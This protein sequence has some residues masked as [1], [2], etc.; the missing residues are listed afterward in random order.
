MNALLWGFALLQ[1]YGYTAALATSILT[2]MAVRYISSWSRGPSRESA[3]MIFKFASPI[4]AIV[5]I[6]LPIDYWVISGILW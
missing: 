2:I 3:R 5:F 1:G 4:M 6:L